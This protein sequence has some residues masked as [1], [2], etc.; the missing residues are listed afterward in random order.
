MTIESVEASYINSFCGYCRFFGHCSSDTGMDYDDNA[1][2]EYVEDGFYAQDR[3]TRQKSQQ[4]AEVI[5][6]G[7]QQTK[8]L[9]SQTGDNPAGREAHGCLT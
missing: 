4:K 3:A 8:Q 7:T 6:T 9:V 2:W 1:C 5:R